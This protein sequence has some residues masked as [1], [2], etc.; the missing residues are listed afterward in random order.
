MFQFTMK[1][2]IYQV[3][4][5]FN[6]TYEKMTSFHSGYQE[7]CT[8]TCFIYPTVHSDKQTKSYSVLLLFITQGNIREKYV[9]LN[10][11]VPQYIGSPG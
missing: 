9:L 4:N 10:Q 7:L 6:G 1:A 5:I 8:K 11:F 2:G 3:S